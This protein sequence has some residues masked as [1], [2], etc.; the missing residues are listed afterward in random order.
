MREFNDVIAARL[1]TPRQIVGEAFRREQHDF[2]SD[3]IAAFTSARLAVS[4][5]LVVELQCQLDIPW[6]L[7]AGHLSQ[8]RRP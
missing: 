8:R 7:S 5:Y 4:G 6:G 3:H 1:D 2:R